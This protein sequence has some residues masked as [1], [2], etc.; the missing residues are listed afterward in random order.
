MAA[1][2]S[3]YVVLSLVRR[4][5][6]MD[7]QRQER[8][9]QLFDLAVGLPP[10]QR[11]Q[12]LRAQSADE[13]LIERVETLLRHHALAGERFLGGDGSDGGGGDGDPS[14]RT[15]SAGVAESSQRRVGPFTVLGIL[16]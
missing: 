14:G 2:A 15:A 9:E 7:A 5:P 1:R 12:F 10:A 13:L 6:P 4:E 16:G 11:E 3:E 8:V